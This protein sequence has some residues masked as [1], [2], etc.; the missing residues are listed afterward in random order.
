VVW[1]LCVGVVVLSVR[2]GVWVTVGV[3]RCVGVGV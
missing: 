3:Y 2:V 1:G